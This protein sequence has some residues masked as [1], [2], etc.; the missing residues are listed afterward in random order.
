MLVF[1]AE[2]CS[3]LIII[4]RR[5]SVNGWPDAL[6]FLFGALLCFFG[7]LLQFLGQWPGG[8]PLLGI[9]EHV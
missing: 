8:I 9:V 7:F 6:P 4:G 2:M 5:V 3:V 1:R